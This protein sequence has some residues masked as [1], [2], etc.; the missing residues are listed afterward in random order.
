MPLVSRKPMPV[1]DPETEA[2]LRAVSVSAIARRFPP[3]RVKVNDT[4]HRALPVGPRAA[5]NDLPRAGRPASIT[6]DARAW[7]VALAWQKPKELGYGEELWTTRLPARRPVAA[8][9]H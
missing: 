8:L 9:W 2:H 6:D 4:I 3:N 5:L 1:L 7:L